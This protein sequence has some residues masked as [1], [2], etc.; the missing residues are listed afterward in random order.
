M[1]R[2]VH[3]AQKDDDIPP[4]KAINSPLEVELNISQQE[5]LLYGRVYV[6]IFI[7]YYFTTPLSLL[8]S[9]P[10]FALSLSILM[11]MMVVAFGRFK[12]CRRITGIYNNLQIPKKK[13][14]LKQRG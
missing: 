5:I 6:V 7:C 1:L 9:G 4:I 8:W 11:F 12:N 3:G 13:P 2:R 14:S 10:M